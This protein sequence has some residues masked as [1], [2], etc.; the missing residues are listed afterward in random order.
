MS[1]P[2]SQSAPPGPAPALRLVAEAPAWTALR[3]AL[4]RLH[5]EQPDTFARL[6]APLSTERTAELP[7]ELAAPLLHFALV[8]PLGDGTAYRSLHRIRAHAGRF[9]VMELG[10]QA[11]YF[12]DVWP[13]TDAMLAVLADA[14]PGRL[15]D[16]GTGTGIVAIDAAARGH[17][18]VA[19][20]LF[21][22]AL[23]L[24][25]WNAMLNEVPGI[26]FRRGHLLDP[27]AGETFDLIL[28]APHYTRLADQ[29]P[30]EVLRGGPRHVAPG[31]RLVVATFGEWEGDGEL[32]LA[33]AILP[34]HARRGYRIT[35]EPLHTPYKREWFTTARAEPPIPGLVSKHRFLITFSADARSGTDAAAPI[36]PVVRMPDAA[37]V[38][39]QRYVPLA[40]LFQGPQAERP[41]VTA[42]V[43]TRADVLVLA[44]LLRA[45]AAGTVQLDGDLPVGVL[46]L[47]RWGARRC[48]APRSFE[49]AAGA[50]LDTAGGIRPCAHGQRIGTVDEPT[51]VL[52]DRLALRAQEAALRRGCAGCPASALC[53][54]CLFPAPL[55]E[56]EY[57]DFVRTH[58]PG[59]AL[60]PRLV[61]SLAQLAPVLGGPAPSRPLRIKT[62]PAAPLVAA[63]GRPHPLPRPTGE[64]SARIDALRGRW[65]AAEAWLVSAG[66][67]CGALLRTERGQALHGLPSSTAEI[68]ELL[69]DGCNAAELGTYAALRGLGR[70]ELFDALRKIAETLE[71]PGNYPGN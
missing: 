2:A 37:A 38:V 12:Q 41:P 34:A 36:P 52:A 16:L 66:G 17:R 67:R 33:A 11:E 23:A 18:V 27:V 24:A 32:A 64:L 22:T 71:S 69:A 62:R 46:D 3:Q 19:T 51:Q 70:A 30:R 50:I 4:Q 48:T 55:P 21:D 60:L 42:V 49:G 13:E 15:L 45:L 35:V 58:A 6:F 26:D 28:T 5:A 47:C 14:V 1:A 54:R 61:G 57:C 68:A 39:E 7:P 53:S 31:G 59:L 63:I 29:L 9:Y 56:A 8:R 65:A 40:R 10:G 25:R 43:S 44:G 20:D